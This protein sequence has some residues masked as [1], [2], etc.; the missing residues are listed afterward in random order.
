MLLVLNNAINY[1]SANCDEA[2]IV[3]GESL[4]EFIAFDFVRNNAWVDPSGGSTL[5]SP[6][7]SFYKAGV[8][9]TTVSVNRTQALFQSNK[10]AIFIGKNS[11]TLI[12]AWFCIAITLSLNLSPVSRKNKI[13]KANLTS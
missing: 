13:I 9:G 7:I 1:C 12:Q 6:V 10:Q 3:I 5:N 11:N 2:D 8:S 4:A